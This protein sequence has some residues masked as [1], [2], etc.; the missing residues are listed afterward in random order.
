MVMSG[1]LPKM[2]PGIPLGLLAVSMLGLP[3]NLLN[4]YFTTILQGLQQ[5][6]RINVVSLLQRTSTFGLTVLFVVVFH[7]N[8]V[9][10]VLAVLLSLA[11]SV[12]IMGALVETP[13][14]LL[15]ASLEPPRDADDLEFRAA[16]LTWAMSCSSS[17]IGWTCS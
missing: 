9:G 14:S 17:T 6:S 4:S 2:L 16:R 3:F 12:V 11:A 1:L 8:L 13:W 15:L 10:A 7:W 5:I